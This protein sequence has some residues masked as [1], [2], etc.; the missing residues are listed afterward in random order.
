M[1]NGEPVNGADPN[2][3]TLQEMVEDADVEELTEE[4]PL[5]LDPSASPH[6][7]PI[8]IFL[9]N[10][11]IPHSPRPFP[12]PQPPRNFLPRLLASQ[13]LQTRLRRRRPPLPLS[14]SLL[15]IGRPAAA[16]SN[17][18][19]QPLGQNRQDEGISRLRTR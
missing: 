2:N 3:D 14:K 11:R 18:T 6:P 13:H 7:P 16:P 5:T 15:A 9:T 10:L 8:L 19:F 12:P 4:E 1:N 17:R